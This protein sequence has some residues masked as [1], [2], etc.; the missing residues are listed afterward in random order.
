[1]KRLIPILLCIAAAGCARI[2]DLNS[3][4]FAPGDAS[5]ER[6]AVDDRGCAKD[7]EMKRSFGVSGIDADNVEKHRI[8]SRAYA[9]CMTAKGYKERD[10]WLDLTVPYDL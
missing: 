9:A 7:A 3:D 2:S 4:A 6:F 5:Q 8:F 1:M 10:G